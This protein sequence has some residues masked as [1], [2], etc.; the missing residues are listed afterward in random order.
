MS[1]GWKRLYPKPAGSLPGGIVTQWGVALITVLI[2]VFVAIW[3]ATGGSSPAGIDSIGGEVTGPARNFAGQMAAQVEAEALRAET[4]RAAADRTLQA[5][6]RQEARVAATGAIGGGQVTMD[7]ALLLAGPSPETG[8]A[9]TQQ[10]FELRERLRLEALERRSRSLRSSPVAQTYRQFAHARSPAEAGAEPG[11]AEAIRAEGAAALSQALGTFQGVTGSLEDE[12]AAEAESDQAFLAAL[13]GAQRGGGPDPAQAVPPGP[14]APAAPAPNSLGF[15]GEAAQPARDYANPS[16]L[17]GGDDP[18]GWE[19]I[20]EGSFL[21]AVLVTQLSGDFPGPVLAQVAVPFYSAD[22]QRVLVPRGARVIGTAS[23][24][25]GQD[26][27]RLAVSFHRLIYPDGRWAALD[28]H[29]LNQVG[30]G[31]LKDRVNRH[32]FSMF[33]AVGAVGIISGLTLQNSNPYGGGAQAF[34]AGAGQGLGQAA[35]Q[36]LQRFLNRLPTPHHPGRASAPYLVYVRCTGP[37]KPKRR[38]KMKH[39]IVSGLVL[40]PL[41]IVLS[42]TPAYA[43][44]GSILAAI[45]R[46]Q[47]IVNQGVQIYNDAMEKI[48]MNGQL[49]ELTDQFSH[50]KEQAL[51]TVGAL[52]QPFTD[53][54]SIPTEFIGEGLSWKND[55]TGVAGELAGAVEQLGESGTSFSDAWRDRLTASNTISESDFLSLYAGQSPE[56]G[57]AASRVYLAAAEAGDKKLVMAHA[58]SDAAKNLMVAAKEAVSSYEGLRNN[59]NTSNTALQQAMVAGTVTQGNLTAAMAQLMVY[60]ASQESA[61]EYEQEIARR[62]ELARF[63]EAER[64]A[65]ITFDAQQAGIAAR[66]DSMRE[67]LLFRV[68]AL[69]GGPGQ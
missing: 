46:A 54:S 51:G 10:E 6:Q 49:T 63:V 17:E 32:Y 18:P 14:A 21:E 23:A 22:R 66:V 57:A 56:V 59:T 61:R 16:R 64:E 69:Y 20:Y 28:F 37:P 7:E 33:A 48:T 13:T 15:P 25:L 27:E 58:Q 67:G 60:Q 53:L 26:Q 65:Q 4:R 35:E 11:P 62:E 9:Y 40:V 55:F 5:Q 29:G 24:V 43:I 42:T 34:R 50:L 41:M 52:T 68:P 30:E 39:R 38:M 19:R 1:S 44:F 45:Q 3:L 36:I 8:R 12:I 31:A 2:L 47:M